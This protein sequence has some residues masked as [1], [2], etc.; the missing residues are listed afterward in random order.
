MNKTTCDTT[1]RITK[2]NAARRLSFAVVMILLIATL[3][4]G[5]GKKTSKGST[6]SGIVVQKMDNPSG[7]SVEIAGENNAKSEETTAVTTEMTTEETNETTT[8][9]TEN[10][11]SSDSNSYTIVIDAG[12]QEHGNSDT[13]PLGPGSTEMKAKVSSGTAGTTTGYAE[14]QLNLD[15]ALKLQKILEA[16]NYNVV[17]IRTTN[18]VNIS[19]SERAN[20]ANECHADAFIR[21]HAN[22][23]EDSNVS[24]A[25]TICQTESNPYNAQYYAQSKELSQCV[26][27]SLVAAT[28]CNKEYVW[29]T[30]TM[31]GINWC[32]VP[33][34]I[35]EVGYM[36][37]PAEE[38]LLITSDY[39]D[40]IAQGIAD[41]I[42]EYLK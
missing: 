31:S 17:M 24:G 10:G 22:G 28:N 27:D 16:E 21:I 7:D 42:N 2:R 37:N 36:T 14:Y 26:L 33:V 40:K 32:Q 30:D 29:E 34:T 39:Q 19:N 1:K 18:D 8:D 11:D 35:V 25:M 20:I 41:G 15:I 3:C 38:Q 12:H 13:E 4:V 23:S 9:E 5:C 6:Q